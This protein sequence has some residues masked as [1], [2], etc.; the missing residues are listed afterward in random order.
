MHDIILALLII[1]TVG[2]M[3]WSYERR[4]IA[5]ETLLRELLE[6]QRSPVPASEIFGPARRAE[7]E[8][9]QLHLVGPAERSYAGSDLP[10][11][12]AVDIDDWN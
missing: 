5:A 7:D 9:R 11:F 12:R 3:T 2:L 8:Q 6:E 1:T 10:P 4:L